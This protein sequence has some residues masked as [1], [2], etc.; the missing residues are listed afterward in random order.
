MLEDYLKK[1]ESTIAPQTYS[2]QNYKS[3]FNL[4]NTS[5]QEGLSNEIKFIEV[6]NVKPNNIIAESKIRVYNKMLESPEQ[7]SNVNITKSMSPNLSNDKERI[8]QLSI[9]NMNYRHEIEAYKNN[10]N[11]VTNE[12][13]EY[14]MLVSRLE[15]QKDNDN[16]YLLKLEHMLENKRQSGVTMRYSNGSK[17]DISRI[18]NKNNYYNVEYRNNSLTVEDKENDN[19]MVLSD[20]EEVK[21]Y[22]LNMLTENRKLKYFQNQVYDISKNYDDINLSM[23]ESIKNFQTL[24]NDQRLS[25]ENEGKL[26]LISK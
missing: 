14:K 12:L 4:N 20:K 19:M 22:V 15:K 9:K 17:S 10:L 2:K 8:H 25:F 1:L 11:N 18:L 6:I 23:L 21:Q 13:E 7:Q 24:S 26:D 3:K 16:K 5:T